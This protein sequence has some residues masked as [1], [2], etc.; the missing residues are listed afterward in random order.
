MR[1]RLGRLKAESVLRLEDH[2]WVGWRRAA[3]Q[4]ALSGMWEAL[5]LQAP[6]RAAAGCIA[7]HGRERRIGLD[8]E[9]LGG[10]PDIERP[11]GSLSRDDAGHSDPSA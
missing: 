2:G 11:P 8:E 1:P 6:M 4:T 10:R 5:G 3:F 9:W 7:R